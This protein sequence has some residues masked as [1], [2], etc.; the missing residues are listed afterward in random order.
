MFTTLCA[1]FSLAEAVNKEKQS[2]QQLMVLI[3]RSLEILN[4]WKLACEHQFEVVCKTLT[5]A[6]LAALKSNTFK[7]YLLSGCEDVRYTV[8]TESCRCSVAV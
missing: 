6:Q 3:D 8:V 5:D 7:N 4:L 2:L 1:H